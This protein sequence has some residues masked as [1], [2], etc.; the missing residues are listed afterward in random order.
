MKVKKGV[1]KKFFQ[2][3]KIL[4]ISLSIFILFTFIISLIGTFAV[5]EYFD[6][7]NNP[8]NPRD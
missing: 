5:N 1:F 2:R 6:V 4:G 8:I 7:K 3:K